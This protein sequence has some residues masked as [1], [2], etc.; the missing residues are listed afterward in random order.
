MA[1]IKVEDV[2]LG[3]AAAEVPCGGGVGDALGAQGVE[4]DLVVAPQFEVFDPLAAGEDV[5]GDVQDMVGF[6]IGQMPLE[7]MEIVVDVVDQARSCEPAGAWRRC[8]RRRGPGRDRPVRSGCWW[9]S[10]WA[11]RVRVR[12]DSRCGR[13]FSAGVR[14]AILRLRSRVFRLLR[15][16]VFLEI[17]CTHS[18]ASV[19]WNSEDVFLPPLFQ[20]LRGF[21]SFF[22]EFCQEEPIYHAWLRSSGPRH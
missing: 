14:G 7:E 19:A 3:E 6:V 18:K 4:I 9:R 12:A 11:D 1:S 13:G 10:S 22:R 16:R 5:E 15:F 17:V 8:R 2:G 20:N 21:S